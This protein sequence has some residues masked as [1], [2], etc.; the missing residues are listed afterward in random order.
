MLPVTQSASGALDFFDM[1]MRDYAQGDLLDELSQYVKTAFGDAQRHKTAANIEQEIMRCMR[2]VNNEYDPE[3][4]EMVAASGVDLYMGITN[5]KC[6]ALKSWITDILANA[7]DQPWTLKATPMPELPTEAEEAVID[8]LIRELQMNGLDV[9]LRQ[10]AAYFKDVAQKHADKLAEKAVR[11][12][13]TKIQD[14]MLEGGWRESFTAFI[15]DLSTFPLAILKGPV[16]ERVPSMRWQGGGLKVVDRLKYRMHRVHPLDFFPSPNSSTMDDGRYLIERKRMTRDDIMQSIGVPGFMEQAIRSLIASRPTGAKEMLNTD[17]ERDA[18]EAKDGRMSSTDNTYDVVC[19]YG[20]V[21]GRLLVEHG[22]EVDDP[23]KDCEAEVWVCSGFVLRAILNPH[24]IGKRPFYGASFE[25]V[26]GSIWGRALPSLLRDLQRV[27]N[28]SARSLVRNMAFASGPIGEYDVNR[29]ANE[30]NID[31]VRPFRLYAVQSDQFAMSSQSALRFQK[32]DSNATELMKAYDYFSRIA[33]DISGVPSYVLGNP[34]VAGAGRTLGGLSMLMG[35]AAKGVKLVVSGIDRYVIEPLI[36][37][38]YVLM[39]L[40]EPDP[41]IKA[42]VAVVARGSSGLL[43]R[44]LSQARAVE[45]LNMLTPYAQGGLVPP[46]GLQSVL[47]DVLR[48]LGYTA[49]DI[50]PDPD[51]QR[52]LMDLAMRLGVRQTFGTEGPATA[53]PSMIPGTPGPELDGRSLPPPN[54][55]DAET[56]PAA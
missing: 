5:L 14:L 4:R 16:I 42:D 10:K 21:P 9:D 1:L 37:N 19:Y 2:A 8:A 34:Q 11:R 43:Q 36:S 53:G 35:N 33:D 54:P 3:D 17:A 22:V 51:R 6:R 48:G 23:Q 41:T 27:C 26:P 29:L 55:A 32:I 50:I 38:Y 30:T 12:M 49:D 45:V 18:L 28:A 52:Q 24:P 15:S 13:E 25:Q 56:F 44:E 7:E 31:Q 46:E 39:M 20:K 47:R 40:F